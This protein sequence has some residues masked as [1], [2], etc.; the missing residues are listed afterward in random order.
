MRRGNKI[1]L[2]H[3]LEKKHDIVG[4]TAYFD[5]NA[6]IVMIHIITIAHRE[7]CSLE[8]VVDA[9]YVGT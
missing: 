3:K 4:R 5:C 7:P 8:C 2:G 9:L 1:R 6:Y